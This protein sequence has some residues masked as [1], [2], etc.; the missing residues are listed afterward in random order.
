MKKCLKN[1]R[2][3]YPRKRP[4]A[5]GKSELLEGYLNRDDFAADIGV[6]QRTVARYEEQGL[7]FIVVGH[8]RYYNKLRAMEWLTA[9]EVTA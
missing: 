5:N 7:P 2:P 4:P 6:C 9:R 1:N 3:G 8:R